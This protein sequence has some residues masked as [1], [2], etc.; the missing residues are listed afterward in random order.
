VESRAGCEGRIDLHQDTMGG[1]AR[2]LRCRSE[3][4][5]LNR[6]CGR[7]FAA[8]FE[9]HSDPADRILVATA[10]H[11][12]A[13]WLRGW[14]LLEMH[15]RGTFWGWRWL[16]DCAIPTMRKER[17]RI[18]TAGFRR[19]LLLVSL[20]ALCCEQLPPFNQINYRSLISKFFETVPA[21]KTGDIFLNLGYDFNS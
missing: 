5:P 6:R 10:R 15:G 21:P 9:M 8:A 16:R 19:F 20:A 14:A 2:R 7:K 3:V 4:V 13:T 12:G 18:G 11:L 17:V 1:Y